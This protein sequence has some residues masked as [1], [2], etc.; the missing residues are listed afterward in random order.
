MRNK[1]Y[2]YE[3]GTCWVT[4]PLYKLSTE[5]IELTEH[6]KST[7]THYLRVSSIFQVLESDRISTFRDGKTLNFYFVCGHF[8][9]LDRIELAQQLDGYIRS[10]DSLL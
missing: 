5:E 8:Q 10:T 3:V 6:K 4:E 7:F 2:I 1:K 9:R